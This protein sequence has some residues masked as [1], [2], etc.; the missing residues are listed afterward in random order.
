LKTKLFK[1]LCS[2]FG[3]AVRKK[4]DWSTVNHLL[5]IREDALGDLV[6]SLGFIRAFRKL[7]SALQITLL[8]SPRNA[9]LLEG[10]DEFSIVEVP[11]RKN[12][13]FLFRY[14]K[15]E[16]KNV[17]LLIDPFDQR[18][19]RGL[20]YYSA[21][22]PK[23]YVGFAK[24]EKYGLS[25]KDCTV[26]DVAFPLDREKTYFENFR[27]F[28]Q[29]LSEETLSLEEMRELSQ[30]KVLPQYAQQASAF[31]NRHEIKDF[32]IV[33][34]HVEGSSPERTLSTEA[35]QY[36]VDFAA[37]KELLMI[38]SASPQYRNQLLTQIN[39]PHNAVLT[40][41][42]MPFQALISLVERSDLLLSVDTSFIHIGSSFNKK[43]LGL[44]TQNPNRPR[45]D[46]DKMFDPFSDQFEVLFFERGL[47]QLKKIDM[48]RITTTF[49]ESV[50]GL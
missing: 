46:R 40:E 23:Y 27:Q 21:V 2:N 12:G 5:F 41:D 7:N 31:L 4:I 45:G 22:Q 17:D 30:V 29:Q 13:L 35:I 28:F 6:V 43:I 34:F 3:R 42:C 16:T 19:S 10:S 44:F 38:V 18:L 37:Q 26:M 24:K 20:I 9:F 33:Y 36:I 47:D 48:Q 50:N 14:L 1:L 32:P 25:S 11:F 15:Q 39:L 49:E 8:L